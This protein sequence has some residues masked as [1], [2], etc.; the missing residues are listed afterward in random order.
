V[1]SDSQSSNITSKEI[2]P[3]L[4]NPKTVPGSIFLYQ[5]NSLTKLPKFLKLFI[6]V[7]LR[8]HGMYVVKVWLKIL[9]TL[10]SPQRYEY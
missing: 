9:I 2:L 6:L 8:W 5:N 7:E 3:I 4:Q 1:P 10:A